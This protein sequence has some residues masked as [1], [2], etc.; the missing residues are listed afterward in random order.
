MGSMSFPRPSA[1][2]LGTPPASSQEAG[3]VDLEARVARLERALLALQSVA[4][5]ERL[6]ERAAARRFR[7]GRERLR[8]ARLRGELAHHRTGRRVYYFPPDLRAWLEGAVAAAPS[9]STTAPLPNAA[10]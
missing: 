2:L 8:A 4:R 7:V 6:T 1:S 9:I 10:D 3:G 5:T